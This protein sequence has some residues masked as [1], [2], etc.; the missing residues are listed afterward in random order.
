MKTLLSAP[1]FIFDR[2]LFQVTIEL[3]DV[4]DNSPKFT[5]EVYDVQAVENWPAGLVLETLLAQDQDSLERG[6]ITYFLE[7]QNSKCTI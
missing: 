6:Q 3:S 5:K 2:N 4:N 1:C 7:S